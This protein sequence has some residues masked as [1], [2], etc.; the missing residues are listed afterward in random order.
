M[1][2][3]TAIVQDPPIGGTTPPNYL[4]SSG[5]AAAAESAVE[6]AASASD[7]AVQATAA[8]DS[9]SAAQA[10][11]TAASASAA[12]AQ[13]AATTAAAQASA[14]ATSAAQSSTSAARARK[15][16]WLASPAIMAPRIIATA[17]TVTIGAAAT[18]PRPI[19]AAS[20]SSPNVQS[21]VA[22]S[23]FTVS[24]TIPV[25]TTTGGVAFISEPTITPGTTTRSGQSHKQFSFMH[26]GSALEIQTQSNGNRY[27]IKVDGE[28]VTDTLAT[29]ATLYHTA[30]AASQ[31][32]KLDF[33][34]RKLRRIDLIGGGSG[35]DVFNFCGVAIG[36]SDAIFAAPIRGPRVICVG[37]SF[38]TSVIHGWTH[39]FAEAMG[40]DDVWTSGVGGT[41]FLATAGGAS[42]TFRDRMETD[43]VPFNPDIVLVMGGQNDLSGDAA[44]LQAEAQAY[45]E[46]LRTALPNALIIGGCNAAKGVEN[47]TAGALAARDGI[48][49]GW[50]AG[51]GVWLD[52]TE[53][54]LVGTP[55]ATTL[56]SAVSAGRAG[57]TG[58][59][60][61]T[62]GSTGI[63][64][65]STAEAPAS[66]VGLRVGSTVDIGTGA[67]RERKVITGIGYG[68]GKPYYAFDGVFQYAHAAGEPVVEVGGSY[69][70]GRGQVGTTTGWGTADL[71]CS[72]DSIH[73]SQN[74][75]LSTPYTN[76]HYAIGMAQAAIIRGYLAAS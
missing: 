49:A 32:R 13:T 55:A 61:V 40:W 60:T 63:P 33:G 14:A 62:S 16:Q 15:S 35:T 72:S 7:A 19:Y 12:S 34:T 37:D 74:D 71:W 4:P 73:P 38:T 39:W 18:L 9:A 53:Q 76:G 24:R 36:S 43:V 75:I 54:P 46:A 41:G 2:R 50:K 67:T 10:S 27:Y 30:T 22:G 17:P 59:I 68:G 64:C 52:I 23:P 44:A 51:G 69:I 20:V 28:Y 31:W 57:N 26:E 70:S 47:F 25:S 45:A 5:A 65:V 6:S 56:L 11:Q 29:P 1:T 48:K 58:V 8:S 3:S 66:Q 42:K 21:Q